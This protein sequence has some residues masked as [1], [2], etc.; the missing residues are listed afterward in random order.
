MELDIERFRAMQQMLEEQKCGEQGYVKIETRKQGPETGVVK[1][2]L[3]VTGPELETEKHPRE[4]GHFRYSAQTGDLSR[5]GFKEMLTVPGLL[6][7]LQQQIGEEFG[8]MPGLE[9]ASAYEIA[10]KYGLDIGL[11]DRPIGITLQ[12][13]WGSMGFKEKARLM[14][15]LAAA[16]SVFLLKPLFGKKTMGLMSMF[17]E[18]KEL[19]INKLEK[20]EGVD[21]LIAELEKQFPS[22][23]RTLVEERNIHMCNNIL[24]IL[25][26]KT[27]TLVV[28]VGIGHLAGMK[29]LLEARGVKVVI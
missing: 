15:M 12:R 20:G 22:V 14:G 18:T 21:A 6:K 28:V 16:S 27:S 10:R 8:V 25:K 19:N 9:M 23:H 7:W 17:G 11:I 5:V 2:G 3:G 24:H 1:G 29:Q 13:M 4:G 26:E